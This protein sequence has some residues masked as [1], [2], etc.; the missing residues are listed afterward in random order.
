MA[1]SWSLL[2]CDLEILKPCY[3]I[4]TPAH[5]SIDY[6]VIELEGYDQ[7]ASWPTSEVY[8]LPLSDSAGMRFLVSDTKLNACP[9]FLQDKIF[10]HQMLVMTTENSISMP[11]HCYDCAEDYMSFFGLKQDEWGLKYHGQWYREYIASFG[12]TRSVYH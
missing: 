4:V 5:D 11:F 8:D 6:E 1:K 9:I 2:R 3:T 10:F 7:I 12:E